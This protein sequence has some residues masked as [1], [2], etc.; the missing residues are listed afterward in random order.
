[1]TARQFVTVHCQT[2]GQ[3]VDIPVNFATGGAR[4]ALVVKVR[5]DIDGAEWA[6][7]LHDDLHHP[8]VT[9]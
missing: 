7:R 4:R 6:K 8:Q 1:M 5:I 9:S 2:C 3:P